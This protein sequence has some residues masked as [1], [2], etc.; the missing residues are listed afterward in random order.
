[1]QSGRPFWPRGLLR[2]RTRAWGVASADQSVSLV[3]LG[4]SDGQVVR[5]LN[6]LHMALPDWT[7]APDMHQDGLVQMLGEFSGQEGRRHRRLVLALPMARCQSG[8]LECPLTLGAEAL[9]AEVQ[10]EAAQ[11]LKVPASQVS[12]DFEVQRTNGAQTQRVQWLACLRNEV[13]AW[14]RHTRAAGWRLPAIEHQEQ[15]AR[16]A[17][18]A[19][20]GGVKNLLSQAHQDW[21]FRAIGMADGAGD[22]WWDEALISVRDTPAWAWLCACGAGLRALS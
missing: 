10:L 2:R 3:C 16:R 21:Q 1:M 4:R 17:A 6:A 13:Y 5:V 9:Q 7:Q 15:A 12:F 8:Q 19:L 18:Q 11:Q 14:H 22:A 20:Q